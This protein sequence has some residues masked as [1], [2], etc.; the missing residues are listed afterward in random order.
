NLLNP[1]ARAPCV[2]FFE[3]LCCRPAQPHLSFVG[4]HLPRRC[5]SL[6]CCTHEKDT[7]DSYRVLCRRAGSTARTLQPR[8][9]ASSAGA[10]AR[11]RDRALRRVHDEEVDVTTTI[12]RPAAEEKSQALRSGTT[13]WARVSSS[14]SCVVVTART[15]APAASP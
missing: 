11:P 6:Y 13:A 3:S 10:H 14:V 8:P 12:P 4:A 2:R 15:W 9:G 7:G 5:L 1:F